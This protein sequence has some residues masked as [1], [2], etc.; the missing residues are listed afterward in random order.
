MQQQSSRA[1]N[2]CRNTVVSSPS[3]QSS[4]FFLQLL[5]RGFF[6]GGHL[7]CHNLTKAALGPLAWP[8]QVY[9]SPSW[10]QTYLSFHSSSQQAKRRWRKGSLF[11][12][13]K[14]PARPLESANAVLWH[15]HSHRPR[16]EVANSRCYLPPRPLFIYKCPCVRA[17]VL[18]SNLHHQCVW[19]R[20][21]FNRQPIVAPHLQALYVD[22]LRCVERTR[23]LRTSIAASL[24]VNKWS[25][26]HS[27][28][29]Q[30]SCMLSVLDMCVISDS[31]PAV[32]WSLHI[33]L[34][35]GTVTPSEIWCRGPFL[36]MTK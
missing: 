23:S 15:S 26:L 2:Y 22:W 36:N 30:D 27:V 25:K 21:S 35:E 1:S 12:W 9:H 28:Q 6:F 7:Q 33:W 34:W 8:V 14:T 13:I 10:S 32:K 4:T 19:H 5:R 29:R 11:I 16:G 18:H 17:L 3:C 31:L 24:G 20:R